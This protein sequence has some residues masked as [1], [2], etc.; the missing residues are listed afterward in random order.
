MIT[1]LPADIREVQSA[2]HQIEVQIFARGPEDLGTVF[3]HQLQ[4]VEAT[5]TL[6]GV[7]DAPGRSVSGTVL[8]E[9]AAGDNIIAAD[10]W[11]PFGTWLL[12]QQVIRRQNGTKITVPWG[13]FRLDSYTANYLIGSI[14]FTADDAF[15]SQIAGYDLMMLQ[16]AQVTTSQTWASR[17]T[18]TLTEGMR[19][20]SPW[21]TTLVSYASG[22][23]QTAK[24][25]ALF[26]S[27][28]LN[29]ATALTR[30]A[31]TGLKARVICGGNPGTAFKIIPSR[32]NSSYT[33]ITAQ[34][35]FHLVKPGEFGNL[36]SDTYADAMDRVDYAN[37]VALTYTK[38]TQIP[39]ARTRIQQKRVV[40]TFDDNTPAV[41]PDNW[42]LAELG[43]NG[44]FG[45][46][47]MQALSYDELTD[48]AAVDLATNALS[49]TWVYARDL[50]ITSGP[51]YGLEQGDPLWILAPGQTGFGAI[52]TGA[53]I[54]LNAEGGPWTLKVKTFTQVDKG[55]RPRSTASV[56]PGGDKTEDDADW[57]PAILRSNQH[58]ALD[59]NFPTG[60]TI[61]NDRVVSK[62]YPAGG[63]NLTVQA[64]G[65]GDILFHTG[66]AWAVQ[67]SGRPERRYR[68]KASVTCLTH[69]HDIRVGF[70]FNSGA[71]Q[72]S[73]WVPDKVKHAVTA[74]LD[75]TVPAGPS[76]FGVQIQVAGPTNNE[77][78]RL[79][80]VS[81]EYASR[82]K[83]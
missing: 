31:T 6:A 26:V 78:V 24:P 5:V 7:D 54:P 68:V 11:S 2:G 63:D 70:I 46:Q 60:W 43:A 25:A 79:N 58:V 72:W 41:L 23:S 44:P 47:S 36:V 52:L 45:V 56:D 71:P 20:I 19:S 53:T 39:G 22:I 51:L 49:K 27:D 40:V 42:P 82:P 67:P 83:E 38:T 18:A 77:L 8:I 29:R 74:T 9:D 76:T 80:S 17:I 73:K 30:M 37:K 81:V 61:D 28:D 21:W 10:Y 1:G 69:S 15:G 35:A 13:V 32:E 16:D 55:W 57:V 75:Y 50:T 62:K 64:N 33:A 66:L 48:Q 4:V 12:V 34:N 65:S 3:P 59:Q 14:D